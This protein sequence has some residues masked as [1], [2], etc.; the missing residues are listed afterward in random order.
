MIWR[1]VLVRSDSTLADLHYIIQITMTWSNFYLHR[2]T[3]HGKYFAVLRDGVAEAH[4]ADSI[5]LDA[6]GLRLNERFLYE[7]SF[8]E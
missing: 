7:Y 6:L 8:Y 5:R 1:R 3:I 2:F 4:S